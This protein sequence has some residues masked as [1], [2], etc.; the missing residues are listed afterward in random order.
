VV[1]FL[2]RGGGRWGAVFT[3]LN[4][5]IGIILGEEE[6]GGEG[7]GEKRGEEILSFGSEITKFTRIWVGGRKRRKKKSEKGR[8]EKRKMIS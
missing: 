3:I 5:F 8:G 7:E 2:A 6:E 4:F 1:A